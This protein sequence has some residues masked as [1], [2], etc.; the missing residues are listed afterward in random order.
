[1]N[2]IAIASL[3]L[4][5]SG[6]NG[7]YLYRVSNDTDG[8]PF[9]PLVQATKKT[10]VYEQPWQRIQ[11]TI[12][13]TDKRISSYPFHVYGNN[14]H[15]CAYTKVMVP[16]FAAV[17]D[18]SKENISKAMSLVAPCIDQPTPKPLCGNTVADIDASF[19]GAA[20]PLATPIDVAGIEKIQ[21]STSY[22]L[23]PSKT[24]SYLNVFTPYGGEASGNFKFNAKGGLESA[25]AGAKDTYPGALTESMAGIASTLIESAF[26]LGGAALSAKDKKMMGADSLMITIEATA[27]RRL[28]TKTTLTIPNEPP[29]D[30]CL[31]AIEN[32]SA[33]AA[34]TSEKEPEKTE[35]P[36]TE[37]PK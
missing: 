15:P 11:V 24:P 21:A 5:L 9:Y 22:E 18:P 14:T 6:C 25:E 7:S 4:V 26:T 19:P 37:K 23:V 13:A 1:M 17:A 27:Y 31:V 29:Q 20:K 16:L 10:D 28:Y 30:S 3:A 32:T 35:K 12:T 36:A 2:R 8:L 34:K 33:P